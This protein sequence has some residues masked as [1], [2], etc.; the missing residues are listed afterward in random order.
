L[1]LAGPFLEPWLVGRPAA[2]LVK[3]AKAGLSWGQFRFNFSRGKGIHMAPA[4]AILSSLDEKGPRCVFRH[5]RDTG[6][7]VSEAS[8]LLLQP[9]HRSRRYGY[10]QRFSFDAGPS[11][12]LTPLPFFC[13]GAWTRMEQKVDIPATEFMREGW[14]WSAHAS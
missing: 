6:H 2:Q 1:P 4:R 11:P 8:D 5:E 10:E 9:S 14:K 3:V 12:P 13:R 7:E